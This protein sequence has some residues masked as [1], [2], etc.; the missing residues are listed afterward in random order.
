MVT[1]T[2]VI[3]ADTGRFESLNARSDLAPPARYAVE[4]YPMPKIS[5]NHSAGSSMR[6][7][8]GTEW[9]VTNKPCGYQTAAV[10]S[11]QPKGSLIVLCGDCFVPRKDGLLFLQT[12][13]QGPL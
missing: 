3:G 4:N 8:A 6:D 1:V 5:S 11:Y 10:R 13:S 2:L 7:P 12:T 9:E